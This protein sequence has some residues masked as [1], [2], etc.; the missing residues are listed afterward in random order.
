MGF[1]ENLKNELFYNSILVKELS[2]ASGV[3]KRTIDKYLTEQSSIPSAENAVKIALALGV[4]VEYLVTGR[5]RPE[6]SY[7][8]QERT[9][10][11][12]AIIQS[13]LALNEDGRDIVA[14]FAKMLKK[15]NGKEKT[16]NTP[17]PWKG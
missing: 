5:Q 13:C 1:R 15:W 4:T 16:E 6:I 9:P 8:V 3:P 2:A 7:L 12:G 10:K 11:I 17:P 14:A